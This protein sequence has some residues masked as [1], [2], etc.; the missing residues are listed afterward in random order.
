[1]TARQLNSGLLRLFI[2]DNYYT[3]GV[4]YFCGPD[5]LGISQSG[6]KGVIAFVKGQYITEQIAGGE[7]IYFHFT[8]FRT[9]DYLSFE[10]FYYFVYCHC[11]MP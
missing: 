2:A 4:G 5:D 11:V 9:A 6:D 3:G 1:M 8:F 10:I 7:F